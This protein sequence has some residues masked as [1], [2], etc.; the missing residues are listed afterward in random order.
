VFK[1]ED[2]AILKD[3]IIA[4]GLNGSDGVHCL[5]NCTLENVH[6]EDVCED[7]ASMMGGSGKLMKVIGGSARD[8]S[9]KVF[10]HNGKGSTVQL[11]GFTTYG[12]IGRLWA[13]CG[14]CSSNGGPRKLIANNVNITGTVL[15]T[16]GKASYVLR[17]NTN[18][19]DKATVRKMKIKNYS[20]GNPQVCVHAIGVQP[21]EAQKSQGEFFNSAYCDISKTDVTKY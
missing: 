7:G 10:Q 14:N 4:G 1:L 12:N 16:D 13:S 11:E 19:G 20:T 8:A 6:W 17:L 2:G 5:G 3:V 15:K 21:G 9:D 18:Y